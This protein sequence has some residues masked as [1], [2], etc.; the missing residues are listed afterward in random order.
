MNKTIVIILALLILPFL[1]S[2]KPQDKAAG[3][4]PGIE[5]TNGEHN[6]GKVAENGKKVSYDYVFTNTGDC[7]LV[8]TRII[9][10]CRCISTSYTKK[11]VPPGGQGMVTVT[12]DPK[13]QQGVF[14]K[15]IQVHS[16]VPEG[17]HIIIAK[18][19]VVVTE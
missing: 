12:Y 2:G 17:M 7:P 11:P 3:A 18:G 10:S 8:I 9:T 19:E 13:K 6:F 5:F 16:N 14:H 1:S 4:E 15:A